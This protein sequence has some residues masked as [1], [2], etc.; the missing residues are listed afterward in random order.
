[1][2][3]MPPYPG[4]PR[5]VK[6]SGIAAGVLALVVAALIAGGGHGPGRHLSPGDAGEPMPPEHGAR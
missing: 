6:L 3:E 2:A 5:W 4:T 1:M